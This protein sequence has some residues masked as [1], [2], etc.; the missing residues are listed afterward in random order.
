MVVDFQQDQNQE[1]HVSLESGKTLLAH[2]PHVLHEYVSTKLE[3]ALGRALPQMEMR[4]SNLSISADITVVEEDSSKTELPTLLN[5]IKKSFVTSK[6]HQAR[7]EILKNLSGSFKPGTITLLLGQPG[8]GKSSL[9]KIL[10]GRFPTAKNITIEGDI[11][12]IPIA[13]E[14]RASYYR[15]RA[16]QTYNAFWYFMGSTV[17]ELPYVFTESLLFTVIFYPMVGFT[18]FGTAVLFWINL[19]LLVLLM[20]YMGQMFAYAL[21]SAE[22]AA[23]FGVLLNSIFFLFMGF[24]PPAN[25]IPSGYEWLYKITPQR[26]PLSIAVSLV[27]SDCDELPT[28]NETLGQYENIGSQLGCQP[29]ANSPIEVGRTT[30][31]QFTESVY[32]MKHDDIGSFFVIIIAYIVGFRIL[33]ALALRYINHQKR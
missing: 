9:M 24:S 12:A 25:A 2:G 19:S 1:K 18:G 13:S 20:T 5:T 30:V 29:L 28:W 14:E 15:E 27:F 26:F 21:P 11:T 6:T 23:I 8:S 22:V 3:A 32:K 16:S 4:F 7:K 17:A 33:G 10:S 31:K